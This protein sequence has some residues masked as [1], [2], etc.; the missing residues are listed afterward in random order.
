[1]KGRL[2]KGD[3]LVQCFMSKNE[4]VNNAGQ[5]ITKQ[6]WEVCRQLAFSRLHCGNKLF[7]S[8]TGL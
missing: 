6:N 3:H 8:L 4:Q 2:R 5:S 1:M 7:P